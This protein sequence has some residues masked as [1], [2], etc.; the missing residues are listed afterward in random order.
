VNT[1]I[2]ILT[3]FISSFLL[4]LSGAMMPGP[5]LTATI[6][7]S[8][9]RGWVAGPLLIL[10]HGIL[11]F[12]L[13]VALMFGFAPFLTH[14]TVFAVVALS[15][16]AILLL[17]AAGMLRVLPSLSVAWD[18]DTADG[19]HLVITGALM[20]MAN[21]YWTL[22]WA[23]VGL[24]YILYCRQFGLWGISIFFIGHILADLA[25]YAMVST[26]VAKGRRFLTD[27]L[28]RG[29]I[30]TCAAF[31]LILACLFVS[32]GVRKFVT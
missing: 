23:T 6:S 13:V 15:G 14:D 28:Y 3:V 26:A 25:W 29:L 20:S 31:L 17:M 10:G 9:R 16:G 22:W 19:G 1:S 11:E 2:D 30:G 4:A 7:E 8:A 24:T 27:R 5:L 18:T 12:A 32:A 21:P